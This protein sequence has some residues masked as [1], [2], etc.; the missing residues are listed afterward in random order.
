[1][2]NIPIPEVFI[3]ADVVKTGK[4]SPEGYLLGRERLNVSRTT[5]AVVVF[6]DAVAGVKAGKAAGA[7]VI[8]VLETHSREELA[9]AGADYV[10]DG[11]LQVNA[12]AGNGETTILEF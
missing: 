10:L 6:E 5:E 2:L 8:A 11:L 9:A 1:V 3:T 4:P 12:S 7:I